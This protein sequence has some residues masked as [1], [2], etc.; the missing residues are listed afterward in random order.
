M[1]TS[2][3]GMKIKRKKNGE[4]MISTIASGSITSEQ[5]VCYTGICEKTVYGDF[6]VFINFGF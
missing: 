1:K 2:V 4:Y 5:C 6:S 3:Y